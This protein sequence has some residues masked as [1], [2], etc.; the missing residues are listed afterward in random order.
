MTVEH[1]L[2]R[3]TDTADPIQG[4]VLEKQ[5]DTDI[6]SFDESDF[7]KAEKEYWERE[8]KK[9]RIAESYESDE[10]LARLGDENALKRLRGES[11]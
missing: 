8:E 7:Q 9:R 5:I 3:M 4:S 2:R 1:I 6:V 10:Y 11:A